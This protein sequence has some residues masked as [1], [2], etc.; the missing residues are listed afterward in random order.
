M[1]SVM[2]FRQVLTHLHK[3]RAY[4]AQS[5]AFKTGNYFTDQSALHTIGFH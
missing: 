5:T 3:L 2:L 1:L 4:E